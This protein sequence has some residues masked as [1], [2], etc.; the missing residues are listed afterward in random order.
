[1][2]QDGH[3]SN[4]VWYE[5][6]KEQLVQRRILLTNSTTKKSYHLFMLYG[7]L[8]TTEVLHLLCFGCMCVREKDMAIFS[9][10]TISFPS[11]KDARLYIYMITGTN[12]A[13]LAKG[14]PT[15]SGKWKQKYL[16]WHLIKSSN[17]SAARM[18]SELIS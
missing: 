16:R 17:S 8:W 13:L 12:E 1:M 18:L 5:A 4:H 10:Q 14:H 2:I 7:N 3:K 15:H 6:I 9:Q 11:E